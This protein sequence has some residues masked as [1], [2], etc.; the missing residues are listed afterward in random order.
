M[1]NFDSHK[2]A[3]KKYGIVTMAV[4]TLIAFQWHG[5]FGSALL[6]GFVAGICGFISS[7][8]PDIDHQDSIPRKNAGNLVSLLI[9]AAVILL[10]TV[11]P[12]FTSGLG[13]LVI[14]IGIGNNP[15]VVGSGVLLIAGF[16][17]L[18]TGGNL[19]DKATTH[20]GFTH[21]LEFAFF[22]ALAAFLSLRYVASVSPSLAILS[23][24]LGVLVALATAGG[25]IVHLQVDQYL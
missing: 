22:M 24:E 19:F 11:A 5:Q 15:L 17:L 6:I 10:P 9:I 21:S 2:K 16:G 3:G 1:G 4:A 20:R 14:M 25:V 8:L 12:T 23:S 18:F 13:Q 7:L